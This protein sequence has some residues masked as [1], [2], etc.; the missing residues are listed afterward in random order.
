MHYVEGIGSNNLAAQYR[1]KFFHRHLWHKV[2]VVVSTLAA[3]I[4]FLSVRVLVALVEVGIAVLI[5]WAIIQF[6]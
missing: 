6:T 4:L 3:I 5:L 2:E 1:R